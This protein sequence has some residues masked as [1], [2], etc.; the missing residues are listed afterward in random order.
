MA[1]RP[2]LCN[3]MAGC[4]L[5]GCGKDTKCAVCTLASGMVMLHVYSGLSVH[6]CHMVTGSSHVPSLFAVLS[7]P[8][9]PQLDGSMGLTGKYCTCCQKSQDV[10]HMHGACKMH[11]CLDVAQEKCMLHLRLDACSLELH[12]LACQCARWAWLF[13]LCLLLP[14][15]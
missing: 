5:N 2:S 12:S 10:V 6:L 7:V 4:S 15:T 11:A 1:F 13:Q 3:L 9:N 8:R 14:H